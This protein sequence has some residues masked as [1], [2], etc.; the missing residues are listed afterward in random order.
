LS[1]CLLFLYAVRKHT[2]LLSLPGRVAPPVPDSESTKEQ[3][4]RN[5]SHLRRAPC[6]QRANCTNRFLRNGSA[7]ANVQMQM[8]SFNFRLRPLLRS[9]RPARLDTP[10]CARIRRLAAPCLRALVFC[11]PQGMGFIPFRVRR[12]SPAPR[13]VSPHHCAGFEL[14]RY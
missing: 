9:S 8:H 6:E 13:G 2:A 5:T 7:V 10:V 11:L 4:K 3:K 12:P 1:L 14:P